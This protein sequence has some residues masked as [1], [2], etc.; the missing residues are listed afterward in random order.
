[1]PFQ[2]SAGAADIAYLDGYELSE[3]LAGVFFALSVTPTGQITCAGVH[4]ESADHIAR[5]NP[6]ERAAMFTRAAAAVSNDNLPLYNVNG[7]EAWIEKTP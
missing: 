3:A 5:Y 6:A 4:P 1:M 2:T 7:A